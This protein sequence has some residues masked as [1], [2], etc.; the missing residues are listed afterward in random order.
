MGFFNKKEN[1]QNYI[2]LVRK[3]VEE[4]MPEVSGWD[5]TLTTLE[6][7]SVFKGYP[8]CRWYVYSQSQKL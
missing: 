2:N 6:S 5:T 3:T 8:G 7:G 4:A 1:Q